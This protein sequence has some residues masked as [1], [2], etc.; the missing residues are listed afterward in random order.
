MS[1]RVRVVLGAVALEVVWLP[2]WEKLRDHPSWI[3]GLTL[4][5][6][7]LLA[8][9]GVV[10]GSRTRR[11]T[12]A[13]A[14]ILAALLFAMDLAFELWVPGR[15]RVATTQWQAWRLGAIVP[16]AALGARLAG[17]GRVLLSV[18][19]ALLVASVLVASVGLAVCLRGAMAREGRPGRADAAIVLGTAL[20]ARGHA[21]PSLVARVRH[22]AALWRRG[23]VR[24][25][26]LTGG[27]GERGPAESVVADALARR[28]GVPPEALLREERS[29][30]TWQNM[31][32]AARIARRMR[33]RS[34]LVVS[35]P[36]HLGRA[37]V[38]ARAAGLPAPRPS[39]SPSPLWNLRAAPYWVVREV[40]NMPGAFVRAG[41]AFFEGTWSSPYAETFDP[42][43]RSRVGR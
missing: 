12:W 10:A 39:A 30:T 42:A 21:T 9:A 22:A 24:T 4:G 11:S 15:W 27:S 38:L 41:I 40:G 18:G 6:P 14:A 28:A 37:M 35:E 16:A 33:W 43:R 7:W 29:G 26:V 34:V 31:L 19:R 2:L 1:S 8:C 5:G 25:L 13:N 17:R 32:E 3:L 23:L 36:T 20:D